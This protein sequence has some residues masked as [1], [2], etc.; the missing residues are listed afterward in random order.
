MPSF[1]VEFTCN[2]EKYE[3]S[4]YLQQLKGQ[5]A[6]LNAIPVTEWQQNR[7]NYKDKGRGSAA[8]QEAARAIVREEL[9]AQG[10]SDQEIEEHM[11]RLAALHEPDMVAGGRITVTKL[12]SRFINSSIGSQWRTKVTVIEGKVAA[13]SDVDKKRMHINATLKIA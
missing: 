1:T 12:G 8:D 13:L 9:K 2:T 4:V 6:G 10:K 3:R 7:Q 11:E 5:E